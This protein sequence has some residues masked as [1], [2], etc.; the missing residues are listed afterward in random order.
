MKPALLSTLL[1]LIALLV[2]TN[3]L[4]L[5]ISAAF[6]IALLVTFIVSEVRRVPQ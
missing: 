4:D 6:S 3:R 1:L 5:R 2:K